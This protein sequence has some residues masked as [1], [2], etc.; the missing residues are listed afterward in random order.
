M[1]HVTTTLAIG[2]ALASIGT[3]Q[4]S[5]KQ[6]PS[7]KPA[8]RIVQGTTQMA[9]DNG[10]LNTTYTIGKM[11]PINITLT[12]VR[13]SVVREVVGSG[14]VAPA[15]D[16]KLLVIDFI[17][18]NPNPKAIPFG[19]SDLKFTGVDQ[20]SVNRD[21]T[22]QFTRA[23]TSEVFSTDLKPAQKVELRTIIVVP[24]AGTVPKLI[25]QHRS[26]GPVMRYDIK[27]NLKPLP[28]EFADNK[29]ETGM[30]A[31][32]EWT[33]LPDTYAPMA[34]LDMKYVPGSFQDHGTRFGVNTTAAPKTFAS[35]K[36]TLKGQTPAQAGIRFQA[37]VIDENG[38]K[39][40]ITKFAQI[41]TEDHATRTLGMGEEYTVR[42]VTVM[43]AKVKLKTL[44]VTDTAVG[45]ASRTYIFKL[46]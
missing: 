27:A 17:A 40:P 2:M 3:A 46:D 25:L 38:E 28:T 20:E 23:K 26:G 44:R 15:K 29:D 7:Q 45:R 5:P 42:F 12:N 37:E 8:Q 9:G 34:M 36:M 13:Y 33:F 1:K 43:A 32:N 19:G 6:K 4:T 16:E 22:G 41:S 10:K 18:H 21:Y 35:I 11:D 31:A 39:Y 14:V 24:A 30:T